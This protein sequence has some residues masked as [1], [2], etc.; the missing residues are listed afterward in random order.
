MPCQKQKVD[1]YHKK[2]ERDE[3]LSRKLN[4]HNLNYIT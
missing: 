4:L 2:I 3:V 1:I